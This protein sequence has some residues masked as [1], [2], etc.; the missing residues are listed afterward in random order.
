MLF[1]RLQELR[2]IYIWLSAGVSA[3][4]GNVLLRVSNHK[5]TGEKLLSPYNDYVT[6]IVH[7]FTLKGKCKGIPAVIEHLW[8]LEINSN[9]TVTTRSVL[10]DYLR[11]VRPRSGPET[12]EFFLAVTD[13]PLLVRTSELIYIFAPPGQHKSEFD[14][15]M[16]LTRRPLQP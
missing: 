15:I 6:T 13:M 2:S 3:I 1:V 9:S 5:G 14:S 8:F 16:P 11:T 10:E 12:P 4:G 7:P